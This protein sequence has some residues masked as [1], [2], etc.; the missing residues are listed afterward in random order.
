[1]R[2]TRPREAGVASVLVLALSAVLCLLGCAGTALAAVGVA[3]HRA[4]SAADLAA[5]A[6]AG[7][8]LDGSA[9]ACAAARRAA[10][11]A[12]AELRSCDVTGREVQ[13]VATVRPRGPL[14]RLGATAAR[15]RAGPVE[16][17]GA[18]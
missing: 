3:R 6:A 1:M 4:A 9:E 8:I 11:A 13:V 7:R 17:A 15:A 16:P 12:A 14:G 5:L 10:Q 18:P 2:T